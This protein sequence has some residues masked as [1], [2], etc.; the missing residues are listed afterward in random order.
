MDD[1]DFLAGT[2]DVVNRRLVKPLSGSD[3]W[4]EFPGR[5]VATRHFDGAASF[6]EITFPT[7]GRHGLTV[8]VYHPGTRQW[9]IYW[10]S[11]ASGTLDTRPMVGGFTGDRGEFHGEETHE[12]RPVRCRFVWTVI[13]ADRARWEQA[14][15]ADEGETWETNWTMDFTRTS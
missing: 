6:D 8:R 1:F 7:K 9:S 11:S 3:E 10:G 13:G 5:S 14:F 4:D 12:G 15:S 2:W